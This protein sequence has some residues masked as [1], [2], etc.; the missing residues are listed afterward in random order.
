MQRE[1]FLRVIVSSAPF[2]LL[3]AALLFLSIL[4]DRAPG[5]TLL[6]AG[7]ISIT[8]GVFSSLC[9][10]VLYFALRVACR[11]SHEIEEESQSSGVL[12][13]KGKGPENRGEG[14]S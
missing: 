12:E 10:C 2:G 6:N 3:V 5:V 9:L 8:V 14:E 11:G 13:R 4:I 7:F 1:L